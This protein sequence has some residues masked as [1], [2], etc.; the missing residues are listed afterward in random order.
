MIKCEYYF[1]VDVN[2]SECLRR[3]FRVLKCIKETLMI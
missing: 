3:H 1:I 2:C